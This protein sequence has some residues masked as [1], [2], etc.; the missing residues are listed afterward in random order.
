MPLEYGQA[1][2]EK[3][4]LEIGYKGLEALMG[5]L[6]SSVEGT[7]FTT[8]NFAQHYP[9]SI[10]AISRQHEIASHTF[11]HS[12]FHTKDL[13]SSRQKLE[14]ITGK[15]VRGLRMPRMQKVAMK[16]VAEAG[17]EY[18][19]SI[20]PTFI[21]GRY[22]NLNLPKKIYKDQNMIRV[23]VSVSPVLRIPLFWLSF[24]NFP[25]SYF[26]HL[27]RQTLKSDGYV[28]LYFH[29]WE[30]IGLND[31]HIPNYTKKLA[32][33]PLQVRLKN[34]IADLKPYGDFISMQRFV[35]ENYV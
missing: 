16:D 13:L 28:C 23:P 11:Y 21:P 29:P 2:P 30:F 24:K 20:N 4:Q 8:A 18:D 34:L 7:F 12:H 10:R 15:A 25:Y 6:D 22:N 33:T 27:V 1:V 17:Y 26:L 19:S 5:I 32:G 9:G 35:E 3:E 31:Y 14:A